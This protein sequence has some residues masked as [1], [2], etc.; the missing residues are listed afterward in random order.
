MATP[1]LRGVW[2]VGCGARGCSG[3][4]GVGGGGGGSRAASGTCVG[5]LSP[6]GFLLGTLLSSPGSWK[7]GI[8]V[9]FDTYKHTVGED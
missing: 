5:A 7:A 8:E 9:N 3:C 6:R 2:V 4:A 1:C